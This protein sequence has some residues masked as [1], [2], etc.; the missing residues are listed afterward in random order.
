MKPHITM[1]PLMEQLQTKQ[2]GGGPRGSDRTLTLPEQN[3]GVAVQVVC[4][5]FA[6]TGVDSLCWD[7]NVGQGSG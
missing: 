7:V 3:W 5:A 6:H 2:V 4:G 1:K